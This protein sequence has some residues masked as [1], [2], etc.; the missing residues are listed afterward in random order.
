MRQSTLAIVCG[1][2][3]VVILA[4]SWC[5]RTPPPQTL[6]QPTPSPTPTAT[7]TPTATPSAA[8]ATPTPS[9]TPTPQPVSPELQKAAEKIGPA[10]IEVTVFDQSGQLLR[11]GTGFYISSD[12]R[13]VTSSRTVEGGAHAVAKSPDGKIRNVIGV[14]GSSTALD[15]ALLIAE[16]KTGVPFIRLSEDSEPEDNLSVA[17][18]GSSSQRKQ[19]VRASTIVSQKTDEH[20]AVFEVSGALPKDSAGSPV[21]DADGEAIG[22]VASTAADQGAVVRPAAALN[23]LVAQIKP[24]TIA[25]WAGEEAESP[26]PTPSPRRLRV[27]YNP[28]PR[29]PNEARFSSFGAV[30]GA[31]TFRV[32]FGVNGLV[33]DVQTVQST[34]KFVLDQAALSGLR[35]WKAEPGRE[36]SVLVPITFQP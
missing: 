14:L 9:P 16:T 19:P 31:G 22:V 12:G 10:V 34:G 1:F 5:G 17:I 3:L 29:Y 30:R 13:F 32:V 33:K 27:L 4:V 36:W 35:Q 2:I 28:A 24:G 15:V 6:I 8:A 23:S 7:A 21:I 25:R 20:G 26:T 11:T 18:V